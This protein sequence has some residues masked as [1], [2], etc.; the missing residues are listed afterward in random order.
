MVLLAAASSDFFRGVFAFGA[1]LSVL[2]YG[3][4][5]CVPESA[6]EQEQRLRTP[7][8]FFADIRTPTVM[9]EGSIQGN[10]PYDIPS[11]YLGNAPISTVIVPGTTHF[12]V[13]RPGSQVVAKAI[14][15]DSGEQ[16]NVGIT[17]AA[18]LKQMSGSLNQAN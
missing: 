11:E 15:R 9:I 13:L 16:A 12:S 1:T 8:F 2:S 18:I 17:A 3:D 10:G 6:S 7:A 14:L 4:S 5:S